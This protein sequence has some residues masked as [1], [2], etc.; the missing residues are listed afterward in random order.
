MLKVLKKAV[1]GRKTRLFLMHHSDRGVLLG[2]LSAVYAK[3]GVTCSIA[4]GYDFY[5]IAMME[6]INGILKMGFLLHY[7]RNPADAVKMVDELMLIYNA[8]RPHLDFKY[9]TARCGAS[10]VFRLKQV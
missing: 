8:E 2:P 5:Q 7:P 1:G 10:G 3:H 9:K 4:D 6:R